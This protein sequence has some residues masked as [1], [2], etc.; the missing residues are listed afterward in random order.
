[1]NHQRSWKYLN[2]GYLTNFSYPNQFHL[3]HILTLNQHKKS[4]KCLNSWQTFYPQLTAHDYWIPSE[5]AAFKSLFHTHLAPSPSLYLSVCMYV[6]LARV[7]GHFLW[8]SIMDN[9]YVI[10]VMCNLRYG[11]YDY[12]QYFIL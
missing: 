3:G 8:L 10:I 5:H 11:C 2:F 1:M 12:W 9:T 4:G 6:N 7:N